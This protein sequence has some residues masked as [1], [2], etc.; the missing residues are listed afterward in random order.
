MGSGTGG[1]GGCLLDPQNPLFE[2][3]GGSDPKRI[4]V[5]LFFG[6]FMAVLRRL[7]GGTPPFRGGLPPP[8]GGVGGSFWTLFGVHFGGPR[9]E[10]SWAPR[11]QI[12]DPKLAASDLISLPPP[13]TRHHAPAFGPRIAALQPL[14]GKQGVE[15][16]SRRELPAPEVHMSVVMGESVGRRYLPA[17]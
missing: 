13:P 11:V 1:G 2:G 15:H 12:L 16:A 9:S 6:H 3:G 8:F 7:C 17:A 10:R 5:C 14:M 4:I